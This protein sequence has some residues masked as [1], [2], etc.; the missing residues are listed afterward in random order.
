MS[1]VNNRPKV[2]PVEKLISV[3]ATPKDAF[4]AF[5]FET[6]HWWPIAEHS[7]DAANTDR[8]VLEPWQDGAIYQVQKDGS[9]IPWG[10][11]TTFD[12]P[13]RLVLAWHIGFPAENASTVEVTFV[14]DGDGNTDVR[15][16]HS[17]FEAMSPD[18]AENL[19]IGYG[20][21]WVSVFEVHYRE[22]FD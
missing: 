13:N 1:T 15:L 9:K 20:Q 17:D 21:G 10:S 18:D 7:I 3:K 14:D 12:P 22:Y 6:D 16:S 2:K 19:S 4:R 5:A 11:V 8:M